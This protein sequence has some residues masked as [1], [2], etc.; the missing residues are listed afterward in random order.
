MRIYVFLNFIIQVIML[1]L[2][3]YLFFDSN[4]IKFLISFIIIML[5]FLPTLIENIRKVKFKSLFHIRFTIIC[6]LL[7]IFLIVF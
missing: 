4:I 1:F 3:I 2:S 7:F 6:I 5:I